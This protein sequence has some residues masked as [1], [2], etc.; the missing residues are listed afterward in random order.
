MIGNILAQ[1][2]SNKVATKFQ[3]APGKDAGLVETADQQKMDDFLDKLNQA[4]H[5]KFG[6]A[7]PD[8]APKDK[9]PLTSDIENGLLLKKYASRHASTK[10][11]LMQSVQHLDQ[12]KTQFEKLL[13]QAPE[14]AKTNL[15]N[16]LERL[17]VLHEQW[18]QALP[19]ADTQQSGLQFLLMPENQHQRQPESDNDTMLGQENIPPE[20]PTANILQFIPESPESNKLFAIEPQPDQLPEDL[21]AIE[22]WAAWLEQQ[23]MDNPDLRLAL[24]Q[25]FSQQADTEIQN[26]STDT[27][28]KVLTVLQQHQP[29]HPETSRAMQTL[30]QL[31]ALNRQSP[32]P[33]NNSSHNA[34]FAAEQ[35]QPQPEPLSQQASQ[36]VQTLAQR[37]INLLKPENAQPAQTEAAPAHQPREA[38]QQVLQNLSP[39]DQE[40]LQQAIEQLDIHTSL[41]TRPKPTGKSIQQLQLEFSL[42]KLAPASQN[43]AGVLSDANPANSLANLAQPPDNMELFLSENHEPPPQPVQSV[44]SKQ[45]QAN[46]ISG[47]FDKLMPETPENEAPHEQVIQS[48]RI[49]VQAGHKEMHIQLRPESLGEVRLK[50]ISNAQNEVSARIIT[51]TAEA[52]EAL[53]KN[54]DQLQRALENSG[55]KIGRI[56]VIQAGAET[57]QSQNHMFQQDSSPQQQQTANQNF[58]GSHQQQH[59]QQ[60]QQSEAAGF[61]ASMD[62]DSRDSHPSTDSGSPH[63]VGGEASSETSFDTDV[64]GEEV[65]GDSGPPEPPKAGSVD[66]RV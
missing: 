40:T 58:T 55:V 27:L 18:T 24:Q 10:L 31:L 30:E 32:D 41:E 6:N 48:A 66:I 43:T 1:I 46:G 56:T 45:S 8:A 59:Q 16:L 53:E 34:F 20:V 28:Q 29:D 9:K 51:Q 7:A 5:H 57:A 33:Q 14:Q 17:E 22:K 35:T 63:Q 25:A 13:E 42:D 37:L 23:S 65:A 4:L 36:T 49:G 2:I 38:L 64:E 54:L 21:Q 47:A 12:L 60:Q 11:D 61:F 3:Q 44:S 39:E 52:H 19:P 26:T 15:A 50:L 62:S